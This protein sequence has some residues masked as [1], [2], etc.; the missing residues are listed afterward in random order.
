MASNLEEWRRKL[1]IWLCPSLATEAENYKR[2]GWAVAQFR[3]EFA[4]KVP[5]I[6]KACD[7]IAGFTHQDKVP[8]GTFQEYEKYKSLSRYI[9]VSQAEYEREKRL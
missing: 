8:P 5:A 4:Y 7:W 1:A 9:E 6:A 3:S 2:M